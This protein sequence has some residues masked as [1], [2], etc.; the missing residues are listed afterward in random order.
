V[1]QNPVASERHAKVTE[2]QNQIKH[3]KEEYGPQADSSSKILSKLDHLQGLQTS[4]RTELVEILNKISE[5][6][7]DALRV[8]AEGDV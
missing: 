3:M 5:C 2:L 4:I 6:K 1:D 8:D 7:E